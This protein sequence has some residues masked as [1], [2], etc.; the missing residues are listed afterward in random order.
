MSKVEK[1]FIAGEWVEGDGYVENINPSD[2]SDNIGFYAKATESQVDEALDAMKIAQEKW[3]KTGIETR[4]NALNAIGNELMERSKE[5]GEQLS[6]EEGKPLKEG[7]GE[8]YRAGQFFTYFGAQTLRILGENA[9]SVRPDIEID[10]RREALGRVAV[11]SPWNFPVATPSWKIA[12]A[13]AFGNAV[14]FKPASDT[15]ASALALTKIIAKQEVLP[16]GLFNLLNGPGSTLGNKISSDSRV[17]GITFTGSV[18]VGKKISA[19]AIQNLTRVQMEMGSKNPLFIMADA[20]VDLAVQ[21][22]V[23]SAFGGSGQK[24]TAA[25][26]LIVHDA[27]Y[28]EFVK[29]LVEATEK[30]KVGHALDEGTML[31]PIVNEKQLLENLEYIKIGQQE[32]AKLLCGGKRLSL[33]KEGYYMSP[34]IFEETNNAMRINRE[35]MFA[36]ITSI[37]RVGSYEEGLA[38]ANDTDFGLTSGIVTQSLKYATHFRRNS[39]TGC[40]MVNLPTAGTDYHVPFGGRG[41]SSYGNREQGTYAIEFYTHVKTAYIS[42]GG[43]L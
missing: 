3:G 15:P 43:S 35:E 37:I 17:D 21:L 40:V 38:V 39:R 30:L 9:D 8:I 2:I 41:I 7:V 20:D 28:S 36:P 32:G 27:V 11:I 1:N 14:L 18:G 24:C 19:N 12:P 33:K 4:C 5:I 25:S 23:G 16:K 42:S 22:A 6:R 26:R 31:G 29:K 34:A 10:V 13:L